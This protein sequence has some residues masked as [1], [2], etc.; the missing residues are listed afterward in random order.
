MP[1]LMADNDVIG[2]LAILLDVLHAKT[3]HDLWAS[4]D[5]SV[6]SFE[7]LNLPRDTT[8]AV[9]WRICQERQI[10]LITGNRNRHEPDS[11]DA[12]IAAFNASDSLP[13]ITIADPKR[14]VRSKSYAYKVAERLLEYLFDIEKYRGTG[15]LFIP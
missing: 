5:F 9:L 14:V 4:L 10:V 12:T 11:L 15:R 6:E 3:W 8:D 7:S 1:A 2:Q 13:V